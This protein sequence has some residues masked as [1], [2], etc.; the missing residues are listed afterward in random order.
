MRAG[1]GGDIYPEH[2]SKSARGMSGN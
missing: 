1:P 2:N